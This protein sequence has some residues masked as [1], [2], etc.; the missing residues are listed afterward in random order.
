MRRPVGPWARAETQAAQGSRH[1]R[2]PARSTW[3]HRL[4]TSYPQSC[5]WSPAAPMTMLPAL[6]SLRQVCLSMSARPGF[7]SKRS[8]DRD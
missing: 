1:L 8:R 2:R 5:A 4:Y 3:M 6:V 7:R